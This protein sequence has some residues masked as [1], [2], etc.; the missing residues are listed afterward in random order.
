M[1][2]KCHILLVTS[3]S[4]SILF[5]AQNAHTFEFFNFGAGAGLG[6]RSDIIIWF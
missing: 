3:L 4:I 1:F 5:G 2:N 6:Y